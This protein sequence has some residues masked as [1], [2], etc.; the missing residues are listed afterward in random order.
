VEFGTTCATAR[1]MEKVM[2]YIRVR[3]A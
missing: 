2:E 1:R 3:F